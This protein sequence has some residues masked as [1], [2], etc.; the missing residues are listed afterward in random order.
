M[1][2]TLSST[3]LLAVPLAPL[4]GALLAG[5]LGTRLGGNWIGRRTTHSLAILGVLVSFILSAMT[6][7]SVVTEGARFNQTI[8]QWMTVGTLQMARREH[9][10]RP[11]GTA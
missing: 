9:R 11:R 6:L 1:S 7:H 10:D 4:A 5:V 3:V 8:Y 2:Q